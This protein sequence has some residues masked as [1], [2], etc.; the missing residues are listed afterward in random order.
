[1]KYVFVGGSF[2]SKGGKASGLAAALRRGVATVLGDESIVYNGGDL[3]KLAEASRMTRT[4][5]L[6]VLW[7]ANVPNDLPKDAVREIKAQNNACLLVTSKR[8]VEKEYD[9]AQI[10][11]HA[12]HLKSNLFVVFTKQGAV[13]HSKLYD[14]LGNLFHSS[15]D[16]VDMGVAI[17]ERLKFLSTVI[18]KG[19]ERTEGVPPPVPDEA[20]FFGY[21][22]SAAQ[23]FSGLLPVPKLIERFVGNAAFRCS[24]GFPAFRDG[25]IVFVSRRNIDKAAIGA[26]GFVPVLMATGPDGKF[27]YF[28]D[29]KP[30]VDT[31]IQ[32]R[33]FATYPHIKYLIHGHVYVVGAD[34]TDIAW[35]CGSFQEAG[36]IAEKTWDGH[37]PENVT[38]FVLNLKGHG[39][40]AGADD[41]RYFESLKF[42]ARPFPESI[43]I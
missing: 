18:R 8:V 27:R 4:P 16:F 12:L 41:Y 19:T 17:G 31:P 38:R 24:Y 11:Q 42:I 6:A 30:S 21:V 29:H 36:D 37:G 7:F 40:I 1:M 3:E 25:D 10:V 26:E 28:G 9:L 20:G 32:V 14:P 22:R 39:F 35:P 33:L 13:Y 23:Q 5:G 43:P 34:F 2:D 15:I